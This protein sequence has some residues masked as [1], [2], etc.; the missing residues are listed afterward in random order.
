MANNCS[1]LKNEPVAFEYFNFIYYLYVFLILGEQVNKILN[2]NWEIVN[3]D[4]KP[5]IC[6]TLLFIHNEMF[7]KIFTQVPFRELFLD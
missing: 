5:S 2:L 1:Y 7:K 6:D 3:E 4:I